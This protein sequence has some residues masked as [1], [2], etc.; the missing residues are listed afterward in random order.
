MKY[1]FLI[2]YSIALWIGIIVGAFL[3]NGN[4]IILIC[5]APFALLWIVFLYFVW[6]SNNICNEERIIINKSQL[7]LKKT[8]IYNKKSDFTMEK[9]L[10]IPTEKE[11]NNISKLRDD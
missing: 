3:P 7:L 1:L 9:V 6:R 10:G 11:K 2:I 4:P 5:V 8:R